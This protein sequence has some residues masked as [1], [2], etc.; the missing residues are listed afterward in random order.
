MAA[1]T[2]VG[3]QIFFWAMMLIVIPNVAGTRGGARPQYAPRKAEGDVR[4]QHQHSGPAPSKTARMSIAEEEAFVLKLSKLACVDA[5]QVLVA[6]AVAKTA[7]KQRRW[8]VLQ[9]KIKTVKVLCMDLWEIV[10]P[11]D[12]LDTT[13]V[14]D[15]TLR[16]KNMLSIRSVHRDRRNT[17]V[18]S[19]PPHVARPVQQAVASLGPVLEQHNDH[20]CMHSVAT[21]ITGDAREQTPGP[22]E[23]H[24]Q[25]GDGGGGDFILAS[26][27]ALP[28]T[29]GTL[30]C[31]AARGVQENSSI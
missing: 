23:V 15:S 30:P 27:G 1:W 19:A 21:Q 20:A 18:P 10:K 8:R 26:G 22:S 6:V 3:Y 25:G 31:H 4:L 13:T 28:A 9:T 24:A 7:A 29:R 14:E 2:I 16:V 17:L 5:A 11:H 12:D